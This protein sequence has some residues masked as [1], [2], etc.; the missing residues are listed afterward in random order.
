M[1][2]L[3]VGASYISAQKYGSWYGMAAAGIFLL[4]AVASYYLAIAFGSLRPSQDLLPTL[5]RWL[6][7]A[8]VMTIPSGLAGIWLADRKGIVRQALATTII[9]GYAALDLLLLYK[10]AA[11]VKLEVVVL[12]VL[13]TF[14]VGLFLLRAVRRPA[15]E[16]GCSGAGDLRAR[17]GCGLFILADNY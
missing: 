9:L 8:S 6:I 1:G 11:D 17:G 14:G 3:C 2:A 13:Y 7:V 12:T 16:G 15:D 4:V 5:V 10:A